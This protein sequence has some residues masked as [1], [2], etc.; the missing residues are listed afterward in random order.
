[1]CI[2]DRNNPVENYSTEFNDNRISL[3]VGQLGKCAISGLPLKIGEMDVHHIKPKHIGG[4]DEYKNLIFINSTLHK[5]IHATNSELI[6]NY[7]SNFELDKSG[8]DLLNNLRTKAGN[9]KI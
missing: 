6:S 2:R 1:M 9:S 8:L 7:L 3:Y 4:T 5:I